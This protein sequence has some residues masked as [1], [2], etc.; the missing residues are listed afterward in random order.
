MSSEKSKN[1]P[2]N[3]VPDDDLEYDDPG[4]S[5][6][7]Q[8]NPL[9]LV[10]APGGLSEHN[11][12]NLDLLQPPGHLEAPL[13]LLSGPTPSKKDLAD[14]LFADLNLESDSAS[15]NI[16]AELSSS[17]SLLT[18]EADDLDSIIELEEE[19]DLDSLIEMDE[20]DELEDL[21]SLI[22]L[23]EDS[24]DALEAVSSPSTVNLPVAALPEQDLVSLDSS[25][26]AILEEE[27]PP[28]PSLSFD[29]SYLD[30]D[31][32]D[33][34][35]LQTAPIPDWSSLAPSPVE[36][37]LHA[38]T[39][40]QSS[41]SL[42]SSPSHNAVASVQVS[43]SSPSH[44]ALRATPAAPSTENLF[45]RGRAV[46]T[47]P[48]SHDSLRALPI[49]PVRT[50]SIDD[51]S[52]PSPAKATVQSSQ[53]RL[54]A[55]QSRSVGPAQSSIGSPMELGS[56]NRP[57]RHSQVQ[58]FTAAPSESPTSGSG[59]G[60]KVLFWVAFVLLLGGGSGGGTWLYL[61]YFMTPK[62]NA[63]LSRTQTNSE[64]HPTRRTQARKAAHVV[65][66]KKV[67][68]STPNNVVKGSTQAS[69]TIK[70]VHVPNIQPLKLLAKPSQ[71]KVE[72]RKGTSVKSRKRPKNRVARRP[73]PRVRIP[74]VRRPSKKRR[75][76]LARA[77]GGFTGAEITVQ[78]ACTLFLGSDLKG[79][80][81][82]FRISLTP[83][84]YRFHCIN[85]T[86]RILHTFRIRIQSGQLTKYTKTLQKGTL[87]L[88]AKPW[89]L[90]SAKR[91]G[92]L[93]RTG[94][95]ISLYQ[96]T[97]RLT[98]YKKGSRVPG[99]GMRETRTVTIRP[100]QTTR[101]TLVQFPVLDDE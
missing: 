50:H 56:L 67:K 60:K 20:I 42:Y 44:N 25:L 82:A 55:F 92:D 85:R 15:G 88:Q 101:P 31:D 57:G 18:L 1:D 75:V 28:A 4:E 86:Q 76:A 90:I 34:T 39:V 21:D 33:A 91:I 98:L 47:P 49:R 51:L 27:K 94:Q 63:Q 78:P 65:P 99:P 84:N 22:L 35:F 45:S 30:D 13:D 6:V 14:E 54:Q 24:H 23:E 37:V 71:R 80:S 5:T 77:S 74:R 70:T 40:E 10:N 53:D 41:Q 8:F 72:P 43:H 79:T 100:N 11:L 93:G 2:W 64:T 66:L 96:G 81:T 32:G 62:M 52:L 36:D 69:S 59:K 58:N 26:D 48:H 9:E 38:P 7:I 68:V 87:L 95:S 97:Y 46:A 16:L 3:A 12:G 83:G 19:D 73:Q 89:A 29:N 17:E 61:H